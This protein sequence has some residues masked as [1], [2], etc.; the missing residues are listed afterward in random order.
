MLAVP[1]PVVAS[2]ADAPLLLRLGAGPKGEVDHRDRGGEHRGHP[3]VEGEGEAPP[4]LEEGEGAGVDADA[5][6][7]DEVE[8]VDEN[9][10]DENGEKKKIDDESASATPTQFYANSDFDCRKVSKRP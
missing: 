7:K 1:L 2:G 5:D 9:Y 3:R 10:E 6:E 4:E 8:G